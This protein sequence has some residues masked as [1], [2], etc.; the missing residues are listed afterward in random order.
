MREGKEVSIG[1]Y[2][3]LEL[4]FGKAREGWGDKIW[5]WECVPLTVSLGMGGYG[6]GKSRQWGG[7]YIP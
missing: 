4:V 7:L 1:R 6:E 5:G 3:V 2:R